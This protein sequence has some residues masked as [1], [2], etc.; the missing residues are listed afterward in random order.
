MVDRFPEVEEVMLVEDPPNELEDDIEG[1]TDANSVPGDEKRVPIELR[2]VHWPLAYD[3]DTQPA[4]CAHWLAQAAA[5][6]S[7][8]GEPEMTV[9][10]ESVSQ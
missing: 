1:T 8:K 9:P 10:V 5:L 7:G 3:A 4:V 2:R 6:S